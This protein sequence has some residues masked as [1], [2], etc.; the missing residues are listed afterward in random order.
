MDKITINAT[1]N[2]DGRIILEF[3]GKEVEIDDSM[4]D[5]NGVAEIKQFGQV[6]E[7]HRPES[8]TQTRKRKATKKVAEPKPEVEET[9]AETKNE[10]TDEEES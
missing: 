4:F 3:Y 7:V 9:P 5:E 2:E 8:K 1:P 6:Y 10:A